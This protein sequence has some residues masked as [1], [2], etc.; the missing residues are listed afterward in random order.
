[1]KAVH[2]LGGGR[3][4]VIEAREPLCGHGEAVVRVMASALC[5]SERHGYDGERR[6]MPGAE[7]VNGGHEAAGVVEDVGEGSNARTGDRVLVFSTGHCGHCRYCRDGRWILCQHKPRG[8]TGTH[9]ELITVGEDRCI[10]IPDE[11]SFVDASLLAD[12][13]GTPYHAMRRLGLASTDTV[14]VVG[15]GPVGMAA[16]ALAVQAGAAVAVADPDER[17][18]QRARDLGAVVAVDPRRDDV[19]EALR[20][21]TCGDGADLALECSA[22]PAGVAAC[23]A[24]LRPS[25]RMAFIGLNREVTVDVHSQL[26]LKDLTVIGSWYSDPSDV[27]DLMRLC[28]RGLAPG[29]LVSHR[30][31][32]EEAAEAYTAFF[33]DGD[34]AKVVL[35]PARP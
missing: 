31:A 27:E 2:V 5:G 4:E 3:V 12:A 14:L 34:A 8:R 35:E 30:F 24:A 19:T 17:R 28:G 26:I 29:R 20:S 1:M 15:Q 16:T 18:L 21:I 9:A 23:L 11:L 22:T 33:R 10:P 25:G 6:D 32:L 7:F 13:F